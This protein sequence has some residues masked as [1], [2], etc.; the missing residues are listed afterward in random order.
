MCHTCSRPHVAPCSGHCSGHSPGI[1]WYSVLLEM[2]HAQH[3]AA[4]TIQCLLRTWTLGWASSRAQTAWCPSAAASIRGVVWVCPPRMFT[5]REVVSWT[6]VHGDFMLVR[7]THVVP[8]AEGVLHSRG[9][10]CLAELAE[11]GSGMAVWR[12]W[13][14]WNPFRPPISSHFHCP[15]VTYSTQLC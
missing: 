4:I 7:L 5:W 8:L 1:L 10:P 2:R 12:L 3:D 6:M 15:S 14:L 13:R 11:G 9:A